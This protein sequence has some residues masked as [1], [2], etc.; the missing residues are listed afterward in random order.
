MG[1][2]CECVEHEIN[3]FLWRGTGRLP[4]RSNLG[5]ITR[6]T[7]P[8]RSGQGTAERRRHNGVEETRQV[9]SAAPCNKTGTE[10]VTCAMA[11][12]FRGSTASCRLRQKCCRK[13]GSRGLLTIRVLELISNTS[14]VLPRHS[15][16][17]GER[18]PIVFR[19]SRRRSARSK[20]LR[21]RRRRCCCT[22]PR[23]R[24]RA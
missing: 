13:I 12:E 4:D 24:S 11:E 22:R 1:R 6:P 7:T 3:S 9:T 19:V 5:W 20:S 10:P 16:V 14:S 8:C 21:R 18:A 17:G 15:Q 23:C 2:V